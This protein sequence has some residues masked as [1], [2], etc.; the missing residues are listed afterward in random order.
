MRCCVARRESAS[1]REASLLAQ[2]FRELEYMQVNCVR[3]SGGSQSSLLPSFFILYISSVCVS[4]RSFMIGGGR[5]TA[6][7]VVEVSRDFSL[8]SSIH[9]RA[10]VSPCRNV[11]SEPADGFRRQPLRPFILL[12][13]AF[14]RLAAA[15]VGSEGD[16]RKKLSESFRCPHAMD[17][18]GQGVIPGLSETLGKHIHNGSDSDGHTSEVTLRL[19]CDGRRMHVHVILS[20]PG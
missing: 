8:L 7:V 15:E 20:W 2:F 4:C 19:R 16:F 1:S 6:C 17:H 13:G 9:T 12:R 5:L 14:V 18:W 3:L 11:T 10:A